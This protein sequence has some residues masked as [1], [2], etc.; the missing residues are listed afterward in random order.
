MK[1]PSEFIMDDTHPEW[2]KGMRLND[3][4]YNFVFACLSPEAVEHFLKAGRAR[5][6]LEITPRPKWRIR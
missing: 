1:R 2:Q 5:K 6:D 4:L 3:T